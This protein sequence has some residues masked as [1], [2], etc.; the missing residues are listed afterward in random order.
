MSA[1]VECSAKSASRPNG[2]RQGP[3]PSSQGAPTSSARANGSHSDSRVV[4]LATSHVGGRDTLFAANPPARCPSRAANAG[5]SVGKGLAELRRWLARL[6][7]P[8]VERLKPLSPHE[9]S[10]RSD[11]LLHLSVCAPSDRHPLDLGLRDREVWA[12]AWL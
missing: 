10:K 7:Y 5:L 8:L 12:I 9:C 4:A 6:R 1:R 11:Q 2:R 3:H